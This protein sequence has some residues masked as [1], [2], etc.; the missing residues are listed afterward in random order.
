MTII[1]RPKSVQSD[2]LNR[3][4]RV[5]V[6]MGVAGT[7]GTASLAVDDVDKLNQRIVQSGHSLTDPIPGPL[8]AFAIASG[9]KQ[10]IVVDRS[11]IP[12]SPMD[13]R[14]DNAASPDAKADI[15]KYDLL[16]LTERVPLSNTLPYHN[17]T[18]AALTWFDHAYRLG[19]GGRGAETLLYASWVDIDSGP[20]AENPFKDPERHI[21]WRERL[22]LEFARWIEIADFVNNNRPD[23]SAP[24]HIIP[25][26][27]VFAAAYDDIVA[28]NAP[29]F[30]D[31]SQ[32]FQD[33]IHVNDAGAY[34]AALVHFA[35]IYELDP[36]GLPSDVGLPLAINPDQAD[37][38]QS[39]VWEVVRAYQSKERQRET[40]SA[41]ISATAF[42]DCIWANLR[43]I[44]S[45]CS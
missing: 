14:W 43:E 42:Q 38:M 7:L 15:G 37:W 9:A 1:M 10:D 25:A 28:G 32:L 13:W 8:R 34:L 23:G 29:G 2:L 3:L 18:N 17:S 16:V 24:M 36:R 5:F 19:A 39:L 33:K 22:P 6:I 27:L 31:I 30:S 40:A 21:P 44:T 45:S 11:T 41:P 26:T 12:G 35:V 20:A 4:L